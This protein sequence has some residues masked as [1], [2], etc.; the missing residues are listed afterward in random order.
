MQSATVLAP[1][2]TLIETDSQGGLHLAGRALEAPPRAVRATFI[3]DPSWTEE[4]E[5]PPA[6]TPRA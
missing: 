2:V 6:A 3:N 1:G 5:R 4:E